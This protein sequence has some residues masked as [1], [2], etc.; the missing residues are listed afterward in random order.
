[1]DLQWNSKE[2]AR[3]WVRGFMKE[4]RRPCLV[5]LSGDLGAGKTQLV[6]WFLEE[7]GV[8]H[9]Q[10][11][12]FAIIEEYESTAGDIDHVDLY[13]LKSDSDLESSG[14][15]DLLKQDNGLVFVE[16]ADRLPE[17]VWPSAWKRIF[18]TLKKGTSGDESRIV[19]LQN[20][21]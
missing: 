9:V 14:F 3:K 4:L 20:G 2:Q 13:R 12:T 21:P 18:I 19:T 8:S 16:W 10:S 11:P 17:N 15:W 5:L 7:L 1:M 6:R